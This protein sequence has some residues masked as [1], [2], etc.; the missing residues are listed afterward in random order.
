MLTNAKIDQV[1]YDDLEKN[2]KFEWNMVSDEVLISALVLS[3][4]IASIE[5]NE[6]S[7]KSV[8]YKS[9]K[10]SSRSFDTTKVKI[11]AIFTKNSSDRS[12][13][14]SSKSQQF[15]YE[16]ES[17]PIIDAKIYNQETLDKVR[18]V[19][20]IR[21]IEPI[22]Y[23]FNEMIVNASNSSFRIRMWAD[24]TTSTQ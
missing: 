22:S 17:F 14:A 12:L 20:N 11:K 18:K 4:S 3:D 19:G 8:D 13:S 21:F 2:G 6:N 24:D 7:S 10:R 9:F 16:D 5:Y 1:I 23:E 15:L